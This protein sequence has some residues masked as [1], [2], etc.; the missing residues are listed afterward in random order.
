MPEK[1]FSLS[2]IY[3]TCTKYTT[4]LA[5]IPRCFARHAIAIVKARAAQNGVTYTW[6]SRARPCD[7]YGTVS[8]RLSRSAGVG[9][10]CA[11]VV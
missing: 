2:Q 9:R 5:R 11:R 3:V 1:I 4:R 8:G 10:V 6:Q 7:R